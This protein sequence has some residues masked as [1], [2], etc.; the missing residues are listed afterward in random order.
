MRA[1]VA[2]SI[3]GLA[4][5]FG[6]DPSETLISA[7]VWALDDLAEEEVEQ[8]VKRALR[9]CR[10]MPTPAELRE[11]A[12]VRRPEDQALVAWE[13]A[14]NARAARR[15][16]QVTEFSRCAHQRRDPQSRRLAHL[17]A[18][19]RRSRR[20]RSSCGW[21]SFARMPPSRAAVHR[22]AAAARCKASSRAS[23]H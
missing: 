20:T 12:G 3:A 17:R 15:I 13:T 16:L 4:V 7:Y 9:E 6:R 22:Q 5:V 2:A 10:T 8:A 21:I 11:L 23:T 1:R 19:V 18:A 14:M